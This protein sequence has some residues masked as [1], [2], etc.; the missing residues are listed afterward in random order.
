[1]FLI[2]TILAC[3]SIVITAVYILRVVGKMLFGPIQ[4]QHHAT[5][6]DANYYE[7]VAAFGLIICVA[8]IGMFPSVW[9]DLLNISLPNLVSLFADKT[10][11]APF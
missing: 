5:L 7:K 6:T 11:V 4:D 2:F 8:A 10:I 1:M 3:T 9:T